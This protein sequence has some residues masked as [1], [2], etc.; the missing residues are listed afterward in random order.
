MKPQSDIHLHIEELVLHGFAPGDRQRIG[1][2][3]E[4]ELTRLIAAQPLS[5]KQNVS[6]DRVDGGSFHMQINARPASVG[7]QI[8]GAIHGGIRR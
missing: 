4:R 8:A 3:V 1:E 6:M 7:E 5:Q 2:A